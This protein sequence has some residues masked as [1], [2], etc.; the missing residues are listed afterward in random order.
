MKYYIQYCLNINIWHRI[1]LKEVFARSAQGI[2]YWYMSGERG[3]PCWSVQVDSHRVALQ[4]WPQLE[5]FSQRVVSWSLR[6]QVSR[7]LCLVVDWPHLAGE[8]AYN[9]PLCGENPRP[10][11]HIKTALVSLPLSA[12]RSS[13]VLGEW[14]LW[15]LPSDLPPRKACLMLRACR[16]A[17]GEGS[18][19]LLGALK[20]KIHIQM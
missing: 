12:L 10:P 19:L 7:R 8:N 9:W 1:M 14:G 3:S 18:D 13:P 15:I 17:L 20:F 11:D 6:C 5:S 16:A 2:F 4:T